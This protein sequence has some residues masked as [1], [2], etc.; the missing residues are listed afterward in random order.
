MYGFVK[1]R[2]SGNLKFFQQRWIFLISSRPLIYKS[3]LEDSRILSENAIPPLLE[4]DTLYF[5]I[6]GKEGDKS[7]VAQE[8]KTGDISTLKIKDMTKSN[9]EGHALIVD[10][11][12]IKYHLNF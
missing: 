5:Y 2:S 4:F 1:K 7:G 6:M 8:L 3:Y 9:E 12:S 10:A 11:G